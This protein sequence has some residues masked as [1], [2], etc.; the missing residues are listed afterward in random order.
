[1]RISRQRGRCG[2]PPQRPRIEQGGTAGPTH[3][4]LRTPATT[5]QGQ[6]SRGL[7]TPAT[8]EHGELTGVCGPRLVRHQCHE[9]SQ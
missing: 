8:A 9:L 2:R 6:R 7:R 4:G 5:E 1:M 3:W